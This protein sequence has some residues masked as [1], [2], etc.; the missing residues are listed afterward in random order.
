MRALQRRNACVHQQ[1]GVPQVGGG[2]GSRCRRHTHSLFF[3]H[4]EIDSGGGGWGWCAAYT[5]SAEVS[6]AGGDCLRAT[7]CRGNVFRGGFTR[8]AEADGVKSLELAGCWVPFQSACRD[9]SQL[10]RNRMQA[11]EVLKG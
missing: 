2:F 9:M 4:R 3:S 6:I 8:R 1:L 11:L 7:G 10:D 5:H